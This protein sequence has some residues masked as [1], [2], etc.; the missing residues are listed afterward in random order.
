M[1]GARGV[2][3]AGPSGGMLLRA[4]IALGTFK[5][6][7][8]MYTMT[9]PVCSAIPFRSGFAA[10]SVCKLGA[11]IVLAAGMWDCPDS[12]LSPANLQEIPAAF[13]AETGWPATDECA[14]VTSINFAREWPLQLRRYSNV[15]N[16]VL[17]YLWVAGGRSLSPTTSWATA[18]SSPSRW[19]TN[20]AWWSHCTHA[21][22]CAA[23]NAEGSHG[24]A[25]QHVSMR[26]ATTCLFQKTMSTPL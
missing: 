24:S 18:H 22:Q 8:G 3:R 16:G 15:Q 13:T 23:I 9:P 17:P 10:R 26:G 4:D 7:P 2:A 14:L 20:E 25:R 5:H 11:A 19:W 21:A 1:A 12:V 6:L